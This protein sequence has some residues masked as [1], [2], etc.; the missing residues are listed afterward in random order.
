MGNAP[1]GSSHDALR[2]RALKLL[3]IKQAGSPS[4]Y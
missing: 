4:I 3:P 2:Y 1:G